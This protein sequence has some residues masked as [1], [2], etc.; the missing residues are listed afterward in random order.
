MNKPVADEL[1]LLHPQWPAP[2]RVR[3]WVTTRELG[4]SQPPYECFN[5]ADHVGD[6]PEQVAA[7]RRRLLHETGNRP[8]NWLNQVHSSK[9][10]S[11]FAPGSEADAAVTFSDQHACVVLTAD[12]LP[13]FFCDRGAT[14]VG[15]AHAGWRGL[16]DGVL[17]NTVAALATDPEEL[18]VWLGPAIGA[19]VFE[20]GPEVRQAFLDGHPEAAAAFVPSPYRLKHYMADLYRLARQR[21]ANVGVTQVFGGNFCTLSDRERFYSFRRDGAQTGRMASV[22]WLEDM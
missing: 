6:D 15:V 12:C 22:I 21:L 7:C 5:P 4:P 2:E 17:E 8:L 18:L 3:A 11:E 13:V 14:R 9:V 1:S 19:R 10:V 16:A 20:V